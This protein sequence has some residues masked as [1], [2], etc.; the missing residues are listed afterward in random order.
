MR[1]EAIG[2]LTVVVDVLW[3]EGSWMLGLRFVLWDLLKGRVWASSC[4]CIGPSF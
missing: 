1:G 2:A 3:S 4:N